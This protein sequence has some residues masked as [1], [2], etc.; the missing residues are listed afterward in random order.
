MSS[1]TG[2][3]MDGRMADRVLRGMYRRSGAWLLDRLGLVSTATNRG[4]SGYGPAN[5]GMAF[6]VNPQFEP[7]LGGPSVVVGGACLTN[8][9]AQLERVRAEFIADTLQPL[10]LAAWAR[11][12]C[13]LFLPVGEEIIVNSSISLDRWRRFG[14]QL[15]AF[16][17][18]IAASIQDGSPPILIRT[19]GDAVSATLDTAVNKIS[20]LIAP[21]DL[22]ELYT[23]RPSPSGQ[24]SPSTARL[25]QYQR[26]IVTYVPS[27]VAELVDGLDVRR[28]VVAENLHQAKAINAA[29]AVS[30]ATGSQDQIDHVAHVPSPSVTGTGRMARAEDRSTLFCLDS[31][32]VRAEKLQRMPPVVRQFWES[33]WHHALH[34]ASTAGDGDR[35][36]A[37]FDEWHQLLAQVAGPPRPGPSSHPT[38]PPS[39][40]P[41]DEQ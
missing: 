14:D 33:S 12:P 15:E 9:D 31:A 25:R 2:V 28:V 17:N 29:R 7:L 38:A 36:N 34:P 6:A 39:K 32:E 10:L 1:V 5:A 11:V 13:V 18:N 41:L 22:E 30:A 26:S 23:I 27:V 8:C 3:A 35:L 24:T 20:G 40:E 16:V 21:K 19:D 4:L 37:V